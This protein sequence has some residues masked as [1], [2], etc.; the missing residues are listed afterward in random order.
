MKIKRAETTNPRSRNKVKYDL[1]GLNLEEYQAIIK[2]LE[3]LKDNTSAVELL[4]TLKE[5]ERGASL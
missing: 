4:K 2:G 1:T 3:L 5:I